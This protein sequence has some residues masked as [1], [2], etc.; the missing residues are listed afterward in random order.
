VATIAQGCKGAG[1]P[2]G[3]FGMTPE[4]VEPHEDRGFS[5]LLV[6]IDRPA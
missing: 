6:G 4:H 1:I 5:W 3:I 2:V